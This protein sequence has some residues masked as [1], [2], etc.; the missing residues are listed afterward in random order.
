M[1]EAIPPLRTVG[2][3]EPRVELQNE[4]LWA[5]LKGGQTVTPYRIPATSYSNS[6]WNWTVIPPS[7]S[8]VLDR[9][10]I[11]HAN[12]TLN[13][14][15]TAPVGQNLLQPGTDGFRSHPINRMI[16]NLSVSF[17]GYQASIESQQIISALERVKNPLEFLRTYGSIYPQMQ[18][19]Y[20]NYGDALI[21]NNNPLGAYID[22]PAQNPRGAYYMDVT[23]VPFVT[24]TTTSTVTADL[25]EYVVLPPL[26][27]GSNYSGQICEA[28]GLTH[29]D[30][31]VISAALN[32]SLARVWCHA[33]TGANP[34]T[35]TITSLA[36]NVNTSPELFLWWVTPRL[37]EGIPKEIVYPFQQINRYTTSSNITL[38]QN[39]TATLTSNVIQFSS[40]PLKIYIFGRRSDTNIFSSLSNTLDATDTFVTINNIS[41]QFNNIS[42]L[43]SQADAVHLYEMSLQNGL[44]MSWDE[45]SGFTQQLSLTTASK[46]TG[47]VGSLL[48]IDPA[49]DFGLES[50]LSDG[51]LGQ[52]NFQIAAMS[53][54][55]Q[56][57]YSSF[58]VD[59]YIIAVYDGIM[60]IS[61]NSGTTQIGVVSKRD[62]LDAPDADM[63]YNEL[64]AIY[65]G[66]DFF[67]NLGNIVR[68]IPDWLKRTKAV[69]KGL[70]LLPVPGA[71]V[72]STVADILGY[73]EEE[74]GGILVGGKKM[75]RKEM[76]KR[77]G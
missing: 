37:V 65:G 3:L 48:V 76:R 77:L 26:L 67:S 40:I 43:L 5:I 30:N 55:N 7:K 56:S 28:G 70:R 21:V 39:A 47:T 13:F 44:S 61:N 57:Q 62:V 75:S 51:S 6:N 31:F 19:T 10:V 66:G 20:A 4:R 54:T 73:G 23:Q 34:A 49:K 74:S 58:P 11:M 60:T 25:Y 33:I 32:Q 14:V 17:N 45:W 12:I 63:N 9:V 35:S 59:L 22:N 52:F 69:S 16:S 50:T 38:L 64:T 41:I 53:V 18:D 46:V 2:V 36:V 8:S 71:N 24:G 68:G 42:G 1:S 72:A 27:F 15:G 29:L